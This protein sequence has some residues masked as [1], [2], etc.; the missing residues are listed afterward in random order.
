MIYCPYLSLSG[1][2]RHEYERKQLR[3]NIACRWLTCPDITCQPSACYMK[4]GKTLSWWI[5]INQSRAPQSI[6][7]CCPSHHSESF[8]PAIACLWDKGEMRVCLP[9]IPPTLHPN[10]DV[11][12]VN[13][14][15]RIFTL[16][17]HMLNVDT[18]SVLSQHSLRSKSC[19]AH[20]MWT[21]QHGWAH[22]WRGIKCLCKHSLC[23]GFNVHF[24]SSSMPCKMTHSGWVSPSVISKQ[25]VTLSTNNHAY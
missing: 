9:V 16:V 13:N 1:P 5:Y 4:Q 2:G 18:I 23:W 10:L 6:S 17:K 7:N 12:N 21:T 14:D 20:I 19:S 3:G 25:V 15:G 8:C 24:S 11:P 22:A